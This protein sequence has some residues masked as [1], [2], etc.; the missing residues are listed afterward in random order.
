MEEWEEK[1]KAYP[2][3]V[4]WRPVHAR[5]LYSFSRIKIIERIIHKLSGSTSKAC[6]DNIR[7]LFSRLPREETVPL[8]I[9][10]MKD[11]F[12]Q[13]VE[14]RAIL[15]NVCEAAGYTG[16]PRLVPYLM[17]AATLPY[18][19]MNTLFHPGVE[20]AAIEAIGICASKKQ[21]P[22]L[23][24]WFWG[25][26]GERPLDYKGKAILAEKIAPIDVDLFLENMKKIFEDPI[27]RRVLEPQ[28]INSCSAILNREN[29]SRIAA[30]ISKYFKEFKGL[31]K[32]IAAGIMHRAGIMQG[33]FFLRKMIKEAEKRGSPQYK[34]LVISFLGKARGEKW[35]QE[36]LPFSNDPSP[37]VRLAVAKVLGSRKGREIDNVLEVLAEDTNKEVRQE[38]LKALFKRGRTSALDLRME[39][40]RTETGTERLN[41]I[42]DLLN[43][44]YPPLGR[45]AGKEVVKARGKEKFLWIRV[46]GLTPGKESVKALV[47]VFLS[48]G[49]TLEAGMDSIK[50]SALMLSNHPEGFPMFRELY[51]KLRN[52][53][54]RRPRV[55]AVL[56]RLMGLETVDDRKRKE[57][58]EFL[59]GIIKD[60]NAYPVD[61]I[62]IPRSIVRFLGFEDIIKLK[63]ILRKVRDPFVRKGLN[64]FLWEFY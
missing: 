15:Q 16:D 63:R 6:F 35:I 18:P 12:D 47:G 10:Y 19:R 27:L 33:T 26:K 4:T 20:R 61:R 48:A 9:D 11:L 49:E 1:L 24:D 38:A 7:Q 60:E 44:G 46:L 25:K 31:D 57:I 5:E 54:E 37:E 3:E 64:D 23:W 50:Y 40:I 32:L 14:T 2:L 21:V 51:L 52:D 59:M 42:E 56:S 55:L 45:I 8:L 17:K 34:A 13:G 36:I 39:T 53:N 22:M 62:Y 43:V 28:I 41:A 58:K 29:V 30:V